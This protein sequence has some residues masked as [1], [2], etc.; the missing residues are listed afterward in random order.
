MLIVFVQ[1]ME[2]ITHTVL[3]GLNTVL[4]KMNFPLPNYK[5]GLWDNVKSFQGEFTRIFN[6]F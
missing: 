6:S 2:M 1:R 4:F 5:E 3:C